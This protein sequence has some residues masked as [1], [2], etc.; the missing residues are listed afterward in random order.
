[1][2]LTPEMHEFTRNVRRILR[3]SRTRILLTDEDCSSISQLTHMTAK[4]FVLRGNNPRFM[5]AK[6]LRVVETILESIDNNNTHDVTIRGVK[7][8]T[9]LLMH[10]KHLLLGSFFNS[11]RTSSSSAECSI[12]LVHGFGER[13]RSSLCGHCFHV[14]CISNHFGYDTRCPL[15]RAEH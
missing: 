14:Q 12:C 11:R 10:M 7:R 8:F 15:C 1:M 6:L 5:M 2:H 4:F 3:H 9:S 13:W